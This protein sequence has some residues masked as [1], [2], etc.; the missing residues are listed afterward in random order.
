MI[1]RKLAAFLL[2]LAFFLVGVI[3]LPH[4]GINWDTINHLPR[5]Q[6][7]LSYFLTGKKDYSNLPES[8]IYYQNPKNLLIDANIP[9]NEVMGRSYYQNSADFKWFVTYDGAGHPPVSDILSSIFNKVLFGK[10][11]IINDI[12]S[13]RVYGVFLAAALVGLVFWW[14]SEIYGS[15]A[16]FLAALSLA[17]YPLFLSESHFNN[18]KDVPETAFWSFMLFSIWKGV[19][20]RSVKWLL[21]AGVFFGLAL[22]TKFN[23]LFLIPVVL[24]WLVFS[25]KK[26]FFKNRKVILAMLSIPLIGIG[27]FIASWPYLW[28]DLITRIVR[29]ILFY[30]TIGTTVSLNPRFTGLFGV[31]TYPVH[32]II[33]TTPLV[34]LAFFFL[35]AVLAFLKIKQEKNK[36]SLLILLWFIIPIVRVV[37][38]GTT[39]YGGVRQ[40]MEYIPA[41]AILSGLGGSKL[42]DWLSPI[43][44]RKVSAVIII[45]CFIPILLKLIQI[46]PNENV[47]FNPLIGGLSGAK[48]KNI[49]SW[50]NTFGAAYGWGVVWINENAE[51][52]AKLV[53]VNELM[54]NVPTIWVRPDISFHNAQRSGFVRA[55]EYAITITYE[56]VST[57]SY[58]D[59]YL[60]NFMEPVY[61]SKVDGVAV[62]KVWKNDESHA[63][64]EYKV[65]KLVDNVRWKV[66]GGII[67]ADLGGKKRLSYVDISINSNANCK[68]LEKGAVF[69]SIDGKS[70][71][72]TQDTLPTGQTSIYKVQPNEE[73][74][75]YSFLAEPARYI[76]VS[77]V[78]SDACLSGARGG[79][80]YELPNLN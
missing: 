39:I 32:W 78:P 42:R 45:L 72:Q 14:G 28:P 61:Q 30:K 29:I 59:S 20:K 13:Y 49:P 19:T 26:S 75:L 15:F 2:A 46:H 53:L 17:F 65:Q 50:G 71:K 73:R 21:L 34:I 18:E 79:R 64:E 3:T 51:S 23:I 22:G 80:V 77:F 7:Y 16:G 60:E 74:L 37:W 56:G 9:K 44:G 38:P 27:I 12:D 10:L 33:Y 6:A 35:G 11:G 55:G 25:I 69:L 54:P 48:E 76:R 57:R 68:K 43:I 70:W 41:M 5:G 58:F 4:Y 47:Y 31:N 24:P 1:S 52:G 66:L 40:I 62:V 8:K 36:A 63:Y 67:E